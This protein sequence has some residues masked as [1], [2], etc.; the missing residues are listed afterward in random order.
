M[1]R[2]PKDSI[3][4]HMAVK[5]SNKAI[6]VKVIEDGRREREKKNVCC[7]LM[8]TQSAEKEAVLTV[9][10]SGFF[11]ISGVSISCLESVSTLNVIKICKF[12]SFSDFFCQR[13]SHFES[14]RNSTRRLGCFI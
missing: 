5:R 13:N 1:S 9:D 4:V 3:E 14:L 7:C 12:L 11:V 10:L 2:N 6:S 8:P